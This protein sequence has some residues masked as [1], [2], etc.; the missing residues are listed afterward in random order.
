MN[1]TT[2][3]RIDRIVALARACVHSGGDN[4]EAI[5]RE[6]IESA[7]KFQDRD[8]RHAC[9]E[10]LLNCPP[11]TRGTELLLPFHAAHQA[12]MNAHAV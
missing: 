7:L 11:I 9:A 12:C 5:L 1:P 3:A 6:A 10:A 8:T 2:Q 4:G